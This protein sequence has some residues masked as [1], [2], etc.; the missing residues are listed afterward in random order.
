M[1]LA[2]NVH[3]VLKLL[4]QVLKVP[5]H[6]FSPLSPVQV[7]GGGMA[8]SS[9]REHSNTLLS[10]KFV[11]TALKELPLDSDKDNYVRTVQGKENFS[12][13]GMVRELALREYANV[14]NF[15]LQ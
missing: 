1:S 3:R 4:P 15:R 8:S 6:L 11:N 12:V 9:S 7:A 10:L 2:A 13:I 14:T 5:R